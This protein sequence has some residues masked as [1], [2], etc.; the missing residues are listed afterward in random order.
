MANYQQTPDK[1]TGAA[2]KAK[3]YFDIVMPALF[4]FDDP[5][6][7]IFMAFIRTASTRIVLAF[8]WVLSGKCGVYAFVQNLVLHITVF[9]TPTMQQRQKICR[10]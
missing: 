4:F 9:A 3:T 5:T 1:T 6:L 2:Q 8:L 10:G 7:V